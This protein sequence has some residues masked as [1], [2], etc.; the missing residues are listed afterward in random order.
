MK[1]TSLSLAILTSFLMIIF[2]MEPLALMGDVEA[3]SDY[4]IILVESPSSYPGEI[5]QTTSIPIKVMREFS[6]FEKTKSIDIYYSLDGG[7]NITLSIT[8]FG[9]SSNKFGI[10]TLENLTNGFHTVIAYSIDMQGNTISFSRTFLVDTT[11]RFPTLLLSPTNTTYNSREI[12]LIYTIDD[13]K[14]LVYYL[15]DD[16]AVNKRLYSN[17]T[18]SELSEGQH[19]ITLKASDLNNGLYSKQT[20]NFTI[21][22]INPTPT[23]TPTVPEFPSWTIPLML[24]FTALFAGLLVYSRIRKV[25]L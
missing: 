6:P 20:A 22:T 4:P 3:T 15:L 17:T 24:S 10:G 9:T 1:K 18:L 12:P 11:Q 13:P 5:Y 2:L 19:T 14:Y 23:P 7:S 21:D 8:T 25:G 16:T